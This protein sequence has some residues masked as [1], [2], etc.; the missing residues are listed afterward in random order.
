VDTTGIG[1]GTHT[2]TVVVT[3]ENNCTSSAASNVNFYD[4]TGIDEPGINAAEIYPNPSNGAFT[5][6]FAKAPTKTVN[7]SIIDASGNEVYQLS[8][9]TPGNKE[10]KVSVPGLA[11]GAYMVKIT[12]NNKV[13]SLRLIIK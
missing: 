5:I 2:W 11:A 4:C 8:N 10:L 1:G 13:S 6:R 7:L 9:A 3:D 12:E